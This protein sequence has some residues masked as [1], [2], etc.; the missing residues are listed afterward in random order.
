[1]FDNPRDSLLLL[2]TQECWSNLSPDSSPILKT[3]YFCIVEERFTLPV[4]FIVTEG[5]D[6][7]RGFDWCQ[8]SLICLQQAR[9]KSKTENKVY[10]LSHALQVEN[11]CLD[12]MRSEIKGF[13]VDQ[14]SAEK[15]IRKHAWGTA[16]EIRDVGHAIKAGTLKLSDARARQTMFLHNAFEQPAIFHV[17]FNP[18][19]EGFEKLAE[20]NLYIVQ[21]RAICKSIGEPSYKEVHLE[22]TF[23]DLTFPQSTIQN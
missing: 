21:L 15:K 4:P 14:G 16:T 10:L 20:W 8:R 19:Q 22:V 9:G 18:L 23:K 13:L 17:L 3:D 1:M 6:P 2:G 11:R 5:F 12:T 7:M